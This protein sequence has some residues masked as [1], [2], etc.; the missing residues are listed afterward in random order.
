[1]GNYYGVQARDGILGG[2]PAVAIAGPS[3]RY[4]IE[5]EATTPVRECLFNIE[6]WLGGREGAWRNWS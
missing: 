3:L 6:H 5:L 4:T 1:M 2:I